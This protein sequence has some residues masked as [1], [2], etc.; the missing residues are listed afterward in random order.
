MVK[1]YSD[2]KLPYINEGV[3]RDSENSHVMNENQNTCEL[4][5]NLNFDSI[6]AMTLRPGVTQYS[7]VPTTDAVV[8]LGSYADVVGGVRRL[9]VQRD[10]TIYSNDGTTSTAVRTLSN[11]N[12]AR[13][14]QYVGYTYM[15]NGNATIGGDPVET[16]DG[17][18][19]GTANTGDM[20]P[21]D[22]IEAF[23]GR[24]WVADAS[25][26][27][28][29]YTDIAD[30]TGVITGG[31]A[32][33]EK[34][35]PQDGESI[36]ALKTYVRAM[37]VFKQNHIYRVQGAD[38]ID[39]YPSIFVGTY[40]QE[41]I[42]EGK[43]GLYFHHSSG[44]YRYNIDGGAKEISRRISDILDAIPR[45]AYDDVI[46]WVD[47]NGNALYWSIGD[48]TLKGV[49]Y[50]NV[51]LRY[52]VSTE[53]WTIYSYGVD[54]T[55]ALNFDTGTQLIP[56]IGTL[57]GKTAD[58]QSGTTDLG[59]P[60][61]YE[62]ESHWQ[63]FTDTVSTTKKQKEIAYYHENAAGA[64]LSY[65]IDKDFRNKTRHIGT[66]RDEVVTRF[67]I[68][69]D[70]NVGFNRIK[71]RVAGE[72]SGDTLRLYGAEIISLEDLGNS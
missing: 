53:V 23:E 51:V 29:Y 64:N 2:I 34:L 32:Y 33:I 20:V 22:F 49:T 38:S 13:Y 44:F 69:S 8:S 3:V 60:I 12:K 63:A 42:L 46:G 45:S 39:P 50:A 17:T 26:D 67:D 11:N 61:F 55:A 18:T 24:M 62:F 65:R 59:K 21:G 37:L 27:R 48:I 30:P 36:T 68:P 6:G 57:D 47:K 40:S 7:D 71:Y 25:N 9:L 35:S 58:V 41:S 72:S 28:L 1:V 14:K 70:F 54:I 31:T 43:N 15:V 52:T 66:L 16:F 56:M 10:D 19:F 4:A 5:L